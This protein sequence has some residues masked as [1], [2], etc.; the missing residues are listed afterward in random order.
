[1]RLMSLNIMVL[2]LTP[3][4]NDYKLVVLRDIW[5]DDSHDDEDENDGYLTARLYSL[6]SNS[7][8]NIDAPPYYPLPCDSW[9]TS[10]IYTFVRNCCHW[11]DVVVDKSGNTGDWVLAF[12]MVNEL[13]R[14][15][16]VPK[17]QYSL[18][19]CYK[20]LVPFNESDTIGLIVYPRGLLDK[21]FDVWVMKDHWD[22]GSWI[23]KYSVGP[24]PVIY[25][26]VGFYGS[27]QFLWKDR[28]KRLVL[29]EPENENRK[30]LQFNEK[31]DSM[32]T[33]RYMESLVSLKRGNE[34]SRQC[35]SCSFVPGALL[36][37]V[38]GKSYFTSKEK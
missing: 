26:L 27:N 34:S 14:K 13:F 20:T 9:S 38:H 36:I 21:C 19:E 10:T 33:A 30:Y 22:E 29:Y 2:V 15:I 5:F 3:K 37:H 17:V 35:F 25:K 4:T 24:V 11:W 16:E 28:N 32:R 6:N 1:M 18:S 8:R 23:K 7:W 12:D 31:G